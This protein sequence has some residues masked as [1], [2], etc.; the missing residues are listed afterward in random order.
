MMNLELDAWRNRNIEK[1]RQALERPCA[2]LYIV[3]ME[4]FE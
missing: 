4:N 3:D 2:R 1:I